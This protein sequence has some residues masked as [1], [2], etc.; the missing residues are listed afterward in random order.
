[1][2]RLS[3]G[4][5]GRS[6]MLYDAALHIHHAGYRIAF[7]IT[8]KEAAEYQRN[9]ED[10]EE[11]AHTLNCSF[12][13]TSTIGDKNGLNFIESSAPAD[14]AI[15]INYPNI[16]PQQ[17][18]DRFELGILNAHGGDL[19]RYRGNA[20][21]AWAIINNEDK[22]G[23]C[24]HKMVGG[25]LDSG[26]IIA[27]EYHPIHND[28]RVG[29]L[30]GWMRRT[31]PHLFERALSSIQADPNYVLEIQSKNPS[32][33]LRCYP[34]RPEDGRI[35]WTDSNHKILKLINA[36]SEPFSGA[37]CEFEG[38]IFIIWRATLIKDDEPFLATPGQVANIDKKTGS[39][40]VCCGI[41]KLELFQ[42]EYQGHRNQPSHFIKSHRARLR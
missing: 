21:Q 31:I 20:C 39:V 40:T 42:V 37:Y 7:I 13:K 16:I 9:Q 18:I 27:R 38:D 41:G 23:L 8:A 29:Q 34:R 36:S 28:T 4:V 5:I 32:S 1:M 2:K 11:L 35:N 12:L 22:M 30:L 25:E 6:E 15:S 26:D 10:F 33:A 14:V 24:I 19:P 3:V 17:V